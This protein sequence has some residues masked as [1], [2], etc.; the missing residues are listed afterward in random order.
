MSV[1][2]RV[3]AEEFDVVPHDHTEPMAACIR[4]VQ[5][6]IIGKE[7]HRPRYPRVFAPD[8]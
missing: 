4:H 2:T 5:L 3:M 7:D 1:S 8:E 6:V